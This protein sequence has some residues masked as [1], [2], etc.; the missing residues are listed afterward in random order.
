MG[1]EQRWSNLRSVQGQ[2]CVGRR[3]GEDDDENVH[4]HG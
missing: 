1:E 2:V 4:S 3:M